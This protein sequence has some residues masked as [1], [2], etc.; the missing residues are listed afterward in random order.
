APLVGSLAPGRYGV[1]SDTP[2]DL[3]AVCSR[4]EELSLANGE[5]VQATAAQLALAPGKMPAGSALRLALRSFAAGG[6][7]RFRQAGFT[8]GLDGFLARAAAERDAMQRTISSRR[9]ELHFQPVVGLSDRAVRH[10]E[11]LLRLAPAA[12][13]GPTSTQDFVI[14]AEAAGLAEELDAAVLETALGVLEDAPEAAIAVNVSG[15]SF[16]S[17]DFRVRLATLLAR[18]R[19]PHGRLLVELTETAEID[20]LAAAR[21]TLASLRD[22]GI[23]FCLDDFGAGAAA[24]RYLREFRADY[25]KID[26]SFLRA[27][28]ESA[29]ERA[30][31]GAM[32]ALAREVGAK[33]VVEMIESREE[34]ELSRA[35]GADLGQG[36]LYGRPGRLPGSGLRRLTQYRRAIKGALIVS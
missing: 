18:R 26:G 16:Q 34:E 25:I 30:M 8:Q 33:V 31:L 29:R 27:A 23:P 32:V 2:I 13:G 17:E 4:I 6:L 10:Y 9:F 20:D 15:L 36:W 11:A 28:R 12:Q 7:S 14:A 5:R 22:A 1:I 21:L 35:L 3:E 19:G 24:F